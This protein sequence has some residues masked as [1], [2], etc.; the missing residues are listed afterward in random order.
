MRLVGHRLWAI[1]RSAAPGI[2]VL[3]LAI[4]STPALA[5]TTESQTTG[6][7]TTASE[8]A[9]AHPVHHYSHHIRHRPATTAATRREHGATERR[10]IAA[11]PRSAEKP[12]TAEPTT[13]SAPAAGTTTQT[14]TETPPA[15]ATP[16]VP[17]AKSSSPAATSAP[18]SATAPEAKPAPPAAST[19]P[20]TPAAKPASASSAAPGAAAAKSLLEPSVAQGYVGQTVYGHK[21][22]KLGA[23]S[24]VT[25][26]PD[27]KVKSATITWGGLFGFF[28]SSRT[29]NWAAADPTLKDGKLMLG[30]LTLQQFRNGEQPQASR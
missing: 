5:Q 27:G 21:G 16:T 7:Q 30:T 1:G 20:A 19:A 24:G 18:S 29:V 11:E 26:G 3:A 25:T 13:N 12:A 15:P 23:L 14:K 10:Q 17:E 8:T 2:A 22:E 9:P 6:S 4:A 28:Q